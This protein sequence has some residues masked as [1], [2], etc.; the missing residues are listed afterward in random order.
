MTLPSCE[1]GGI[2]SGNRGCFTSSGMG[3]DLSDKAAA[4]ARVLLQL[5]VQLEVVST[6]SDELRGEDN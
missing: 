2:V 5:V 3:K 6:E 1:D 4:L